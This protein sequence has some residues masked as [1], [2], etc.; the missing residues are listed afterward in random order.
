MSKPPSPV[1]LP[2]QGADLGFKQVDL[3]VFGR[4]Q[5]QRPTSLSFGFPQLMILAS[6]DDLSCSEQRNEPV[7]FGFQSAASAEE[8]ET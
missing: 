5:R 8:E 7:V 4:Q 1:P 3:A 2:F 6:V